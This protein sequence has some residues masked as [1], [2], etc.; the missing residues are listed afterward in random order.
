LTA[1]PN[2]GGAC[3]RYELIRDDADERLREIMG[4]RRT[5][6]AGILVIVASATGVILVPGSAQAETLRGEEYWLTSLRI[7]QAQQLSNGGQGVT[8]AILDTGVY[9]QH[10]D[11]SGQVLRGTGVGTNAS[12]DGWHD[13][14]GH[15]TSMASLVAAKG[16]SSSHLLGIA[17]KAK[18]LPIANGIPFTPDDLS[19]GIHYA[20]DHGAKVI[21]ISEGGPV[22]GPQ[23]VVDAVNYALSKNVVVVASAGNIAADNTTRVAYPANIP[24]VIA[25]SATDKSNDAWSG[26]AQ[27]PEVVIAAPGVGVFGAAPPDKSSTGYSIGDG[28][29]GAGAIVSGVV[30]L[31]RAK[32]P[33][34]DAANV[35]NRLISTAQDT[36]APGRD[37]SYGFG[38]VDPVAALTANVSAVTQNPLAAATGSAPSAGPSQR[39]IKRDEGAP[40]SIGVTN[41]AGAIAQV[42]VCLGVVVGLVILVVFLTRR[43]RRRAAAQRA[44][45]P[46]GQFL[47]PSAPPGWPPPPGRGGPG[48]GQP[49]AG[50]PGQHPYAGY[51]PPQGPPAGPPGAGG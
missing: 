51:P 49:W 8:V 34:L 5:V 15:G 12:G 25:V 22:S 2:W 17:P 11:L 10:P 39:S 20:V 33:D 36:G 9:P 44:V 38:L 32:Y 35:I 40:I 16:G 24:G 30:A 41:K 19:Q 26:S 47:P 6:A 18:I 13:I 50:P 7:A 4:A 45:Q 46:P 27:G 3:H 43:S 42:A 21:N 31:I 1:A 28:T 48:Q 29:S 23:P 14:S 37:P